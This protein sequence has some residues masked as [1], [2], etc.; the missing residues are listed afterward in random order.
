[1]PAAQRPPSDLITE[2]TP[3]DSLRVEG[4]IKSV[5]CG[6]EDDWAFHLEHDGQTLTFHRKGGFAFGFSDSLWYGEDHI[7][8]CYHLEGL[9]T[10]VHYRPGANASYA[11]DIAEIEIRDDLPAPAAKAALA[12]HGDSH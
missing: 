8:M 7:T 9:R 5:T 3:K 1:V 6:K 4:T 10:V 2:T 11:G 12:A